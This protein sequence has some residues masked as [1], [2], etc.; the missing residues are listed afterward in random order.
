MSQQE[1]SRKLQEEERRTG[2]EKNFLNQDS[3]QLTGTH[4]LRPLERHRSL[5]WEAPPSQAT[6][7]VSVSSTGS[8]DGLTLSRDLLPPPSSWDCAYIVDPLWASVS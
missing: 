6:L 1:Q 7:S 5:G 3:G 8:G 2:R 4:R